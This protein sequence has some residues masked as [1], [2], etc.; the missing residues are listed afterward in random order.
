MYPK[1]EEI[2]RDPP[3][4]SQETIDIVIEWKK[5]FMRKWRKSTNAEK[6]NALNKLLYCIQIME[7]SGMPIAKNKQTTC[8][9]YSR[10]KQTIYHNK[11]NPS[12]I[13]SLHELAHHLFG[14]NELN[15]CRWS[16]HL[17]KITFPSAFEK[18]RWQDHLLVK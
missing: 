14:K 6:I 9:K 1:K 18:L 5:T 8:Y 10:K 17:F 12:I 2:L 15:A 7:N 16:I 3:K 4:I 11:N 13:S